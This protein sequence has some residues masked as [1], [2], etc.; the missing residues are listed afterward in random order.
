MTAVISRELHVL[1]TLP[2]SKALEPLKPE[3]PQTQTQRTPQVLSE[4]PSETG[5]DLPEDASVNDLEPGVEGMG[6]IGFRE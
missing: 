2:D 5:L 1:G 3:K 4:P 6:L